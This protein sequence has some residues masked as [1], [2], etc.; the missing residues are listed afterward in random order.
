MPS[1]SESAGKKEPLSSLPLLRGL[2]WCVGILCVIGCFNVYS[3]TYY[4][5]LSGG[6]APYRDLGKHAVYLAIGVTVLVI[7]RYCPFLWRTYSC[8]RVFYVLIGGLLLAVFAAGV[9]VNG[10]TR[11]FAVGPVSVQ[12]SEFAKVASILAAAFSLSRLLRE[13]RRI[14]LLACPL[15]LLARMVCGMLHR[16]YRGAPVAWKDLRRMYKPLFVPAV[17]FAFVMEQPDM[18]TAALIMVFPL[19]LYFLAG[20]SRGEVIAVIF[21]AVAFMAGLAMIEPY[22]M[23][24]LMIFLHPDSDPAGKGYQLAQ[25][26][27]A[28]GSGGFWGQGLG[29]GLSKFFFLPERNTDFAFAVLGQEGGFALAAAT[30]C[31]F[32]AIL[33]IGFR[34]AS[35]IPDTAA[36]LAVYGLTLLI[37]GQG[38]V[39]IA[40]VIGCFPVTGVPL[41]FIS[42]GGSALVTNCAAVGIIA[43]A[44]HEGERL[45]REKKE[46]TA[47]VFQP[48]PLRKV[49]GAVFEP[50]PEEGYR[51]YSDDRF[52]RY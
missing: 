32:F 48:V 41:P 24:R 50:P 12:P 20:L 11:W 47:P 46:E 43:G 2:Y 23:D 25:S 39:N 7:L 21:I 31:L 45:R 9:T 35:R 4:A 42:A 49:S 13:E 33:Y 8:R 34:L 17:F 1:H 6:I 52:R 26:L 14:S 38:L 5:N 51:P 36:A 44:V 10:A 18:G 37:S 27:I 22:R 40:M 16:P 19:A 30:L 15:C 29:W 3:A 28:V